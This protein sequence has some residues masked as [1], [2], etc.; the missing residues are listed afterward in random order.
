[1][2]KYPLDHRGRFEHHPEGDPLRELIQLLMLVVILTGDPLEKLLLLLLL[3]VVL[4]AGR[5]G[6]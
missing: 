1:M 5:R 2:R 6:R 4:L 3:V